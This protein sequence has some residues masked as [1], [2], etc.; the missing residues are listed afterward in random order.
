MED[1]LPFKGG[2][3]VS[4]FRAGCLVSP[5]GRVHRG[6]GNDGPADVG[7]LCASWCLRLEDVF[8]LRMPGQRAAL[9]FF[10]PFSIKGMIREYIRV[11]RAPLII[12]FIKAPCAC[13]LSAGFY[14]RALCCRL[15]FS[16]RCMPAKWVFEG[17]LIMGPLNLINRLI[18]IKN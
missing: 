8:A 3:G 5:N 10:M 1:A 16:Y 13:V 11:Q 12:W 15:N 7:L 2:G 18:R 6:K 4:L 9:S 14:W 17:P